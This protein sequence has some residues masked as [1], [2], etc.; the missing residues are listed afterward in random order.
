[1]TPKYQPGLGEWYWFVDSTGGI[2]RE[3]FGTPQDVERARI[4]NCFP[5]TAEGEQQAEAMAKQFKE[6]LLK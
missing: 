1:M 2:L 4:H 3:A 5:H 6:I